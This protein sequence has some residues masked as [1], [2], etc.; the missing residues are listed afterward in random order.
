MKH[1]ELVELETYLN[2]LYGDVAELVDARDLSPRVER[3]AGSTPVIPTIHY[4][5][6]FC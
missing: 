3:R 1:V 4:L 5:L 2:K 6:P